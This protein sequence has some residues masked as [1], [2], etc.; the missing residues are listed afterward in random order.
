MAGLLGFDE[1]AVVLVDNKLVGLKLLAAAADMLAGV[2]DKL[3]V[4][5]DRLVVVAY[6]LAAA[7][8]F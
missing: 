1:L 8:E 4:V 3:A 5:A 2:V 6:K 7:L